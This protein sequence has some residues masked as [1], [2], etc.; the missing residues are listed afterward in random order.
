MTEIKK[1]KEKILFIMNP[2]SG[3]RQQQKGSFVKLIEEHLDHTKFDHELVQSASAEHATE[4]AQQAV[5]D[6]TDILVAIGGDGSVNQVARALIGTETILGIIPA[7][8]GNG[9]SHYLEI[10]TNVVEAIK[11]INRRKITRID[12]V[13]INNEIFFSIAGVGFD[14]LIAKKYSQYGRRGFL[15]YFRLVTE[16]YPL[17]KPKKYILTIDGQVISTRALMITFANSNQFGYNTVI[18]P[19]ASVDDGLLDVCIVK[20]A[21]LVVIPV[22]SHLIF[23]K[24]IDQSEYVTI[25]KGRHVEVKRSKNRRINLDGESIKLTKNLVLDVNPK[26]VR[27]IVP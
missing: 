25:I 13:N 3:G 14:A 10:P 19:G 9:L 12:S 20:K 16:L 4:L 5:R 23:T 18:A 1:T 17:Y 24:K 7:G 6:Q 2:I 22:I 21:P 26:S 27:I 11:I 8:S 15:P